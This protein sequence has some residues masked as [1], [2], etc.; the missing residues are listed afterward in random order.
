MTRE[1]GKDYPNPA[2]SRPNEHVLELPYASLLELQ[3]A[4][5][6]MGDT[7]V[8]DVRADFIVTPTAPR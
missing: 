6:K 4:V 1:P 2:L 8:R 3:T 7:A 5:R